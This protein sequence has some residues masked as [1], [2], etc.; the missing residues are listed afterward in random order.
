MNLVNKHNFNKSKKFKENHQKRYNKYEEKT[1]SLFDLFSDLKNINY[2][3]KYHKHLYN[4]K[5]V[6]KYKQENPE[7]FI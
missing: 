4:K 7:R 6:D 3:L 5:Y 1:N 2:N